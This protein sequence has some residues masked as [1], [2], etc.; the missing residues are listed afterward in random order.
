[1]NSD[2]VELSRTLDEA[3]RHLAELEALDSHRRA[4][5]AKAHHTLDLLKRHRH[6]GR[7]PMWEE[8]PRAAFRLLALSLGSAALTAGASAL[9]STLGGAAIVLSFALLI[10]EGA[11]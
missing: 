7:V 10:I 4:Q 9:D 6:R 5:L 11:R 1:V 8:A 2:D 3:R